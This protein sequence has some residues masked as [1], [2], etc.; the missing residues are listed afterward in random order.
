MMRYWGELPVASAP[1]GRSSFD[2]LQREFRQVEMQDPPL[3]Q[4]SAQ[5]PRPT[6]MLDIPSEPCSL[7][8]HTV[9]LSQHARRLRGLIVAAQQ[10]Q[11]PLSTSSEPQGVFKSEDGDPLPPRPAT[12]TVPDD[13]L[14]LDSKAPR[15]PFQLRH[16]DPETDFYKGKGEPVTELSWPSCR[17][18]LYQSI[19]TVL[20]HAG[21]ESANESVLETLT[22]LVHEHYLRLTKLL[23]VAVDR[24]ACQGSTH[25]PDVVEQVFHE[26]GIGSSV[27][28]LQ[29][30]WQVRI[31]DYHSYMLQVCKELS[32]EYEMLV[33]PE[34]AVEESKPLKVKEEPVSNIAFPLSEEP[35][36]DLASG[37]QALPISVLGTSSERLTGGLEEGQSPHT[38]GTAGNSSPLWHLAQV[39]MEPHDS[40]EG[41]VS[42][43]GVLGGDVFEE[44][45]M[46]TMSEAGIPPSPGGSEG[47]CVSHSPD[48]LMGTSPFAQRPKKRMRKV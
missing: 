48:S 36:A 9:Q 15:Q 5:R 18:L 45:P 41:Q 28:A 34:R 1:S 37:D 39:K 21:F 33:N 11:Q 19:A 20:A 40:E 16:S 25:F 23:R 2:L 32:E 42:G 8:I 7:T 31:K 47:S 30:F 44:G 46:S 27:L 3:H 26:M 14:P 38:S 6:T 17:Q 35:E 4:P 29:R 43:H 22:D 13:I 24:E 10:G 12:P